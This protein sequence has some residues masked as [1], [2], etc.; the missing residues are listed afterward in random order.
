MAATSTKG[1]IDASILYVCS[2]IDDIL[3]I[4]YR[5]LWNKASDGISIH[6]KPMSVRE[7]WQ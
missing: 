3:E 4:G 1:S 7:I 6:D 5:H 2:L